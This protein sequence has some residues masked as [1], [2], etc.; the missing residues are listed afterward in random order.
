VV[1]FQAY[2]KKI[3]MKKR[4]IFALRAWQAI[5][6]WVL[7]SSFP[8]LTAA[9]SPPKLPRS[10]SGLMQKLNSI[11]KLPDANLRRKKLEDLW[12]QLTDAG[13]IPFTDKDSVL[14]LY[15][16]P[17]NSVK[18]V[19]DFSTWNSPLPARQLYNL[20]V[21]VLAWKLPSDARIDYKL[22]LDGRW[23]T[24]PANPYQQWG[25]SGP[26][27]E[28][29]MPDWK[30]NPFAQPAPRRSQ[31]T[32][33]QPMLFQS[34]ELGYTVQYRVY[35]PK[36]AASSY[37]V[38]YVTD[39]HEYADEQLGAMVHTLDNLI[40]KKQVPPLMAVF[41]DPRRPDTTRINRRQSELPMNPRYADFVAKE[42]IPH[43]DSK[44][45]SSK[46]GRALIGTSL[47][48][49]FTAYAGLRHPETFD[50]LGIQSPAFWY[51]PRILEDHKQ[52]GK[53]D[54]KV[55]MSTGVIYDTQEHARL[56]KQV[57]EEKGIDL[58][59]TE[60]N[61]G[62]SWGNWKASLPDMLRFFYGR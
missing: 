19:G 6:F 39:G 60:R 46:S 57:M 20:P 59:Y 42:L 5:C 28:L 10:I 33:S 53:N 30:P 32:L 36:K 48:G 47:G 31:G 29:R 1:I 13:K 3:V 45:P 56:M 15:K 26:N 17:A 7:I 24:D 49:L 62:H 18:V 12:S 4:R 25:G 16:G 9:S 14:F 27:S 44:Y 55:F 38:V 37:P 2:G 22:I 34:Q 23:L 50:Y 52:A 8:M 43:I 11:G 21:W 58:M 51:K 54:Q 35:T 61:E 40:R 41:I